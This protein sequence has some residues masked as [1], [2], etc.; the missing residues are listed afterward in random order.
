MIFSIVSKIFQVCHNR[1]RFNE[2][3]SMKF[4][5][6]AGSLQF[7]FMTLHCHFQDLDSLLMHELLVII[8]ALLFVVI[9]W[10][11]I[12]AQFDLLTKG[13]PIIFRLSNILKYFHIKHLC[14]CFSLVG[15]KLQKTCQ[16]LPHLRRG[17]LESLFEWILKFDFLGD[18]MDVRHLVFTFL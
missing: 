9:N 3:L 17:V 13:N 11:E 10:P 2:S 1:S 8:L 5:K 4:I 6:N 18:Q 12:R 16:K 7:A 15:I 14:S